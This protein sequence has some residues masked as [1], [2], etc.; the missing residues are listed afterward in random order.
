MLNQLRDEIANVTAGDI[1]RLPGRLVVVSAPAV[2]RALAY[3]D[4]IHKVVEVTGVDVYTQAPVRTLAVPD[5][6]VTVIR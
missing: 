6:R 3:G 5:Q 1:V 4:E 2:P